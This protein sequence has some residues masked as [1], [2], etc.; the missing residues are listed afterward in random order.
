MDQ[1]KRDVD[2]CH[3]EHVS[4]C[5]G[6]NLDVINDVNVDIEEADPQ[7]LRPPLEGTMIES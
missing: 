4:V 1:E 7:V 5:L 3:C 6:V 2:R